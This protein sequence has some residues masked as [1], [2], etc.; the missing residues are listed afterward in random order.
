MILWTIFRNSLPLQ[1][2]ALAVVGW[3]ALKGNNVYQRHVGANRVIESVKEKSD[4]DAKT[5]DAVRD[6]VATGKRGLRDPNRR[7]E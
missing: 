3:G 5:A 7:S 1:L 6:A 2:V 4:A